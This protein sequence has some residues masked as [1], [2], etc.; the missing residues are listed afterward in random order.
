MSRSVV[1]VV[2]AAVLGAGAACGAD[3]AVVAQESS[4]APAESSSGPM[5]DSTSSGTG[6]TGGGESTSGTAPG[7]TGT[8]SS[9]EGEATHQPYFDVGQQPDLPP[10]D[11]TTGEPI[12]WDC[13]EL[14]QPFESET[15]LVGPRGYHDVYFN[16]DGQIIGW[17]GNSLVASTYEGE[18]SVFLPGVNSAQGMDVLENW[19]LLYVNDYGEM[20]MVTP[21]LVQ[22]TVSTAVSGAYG[23][24][25]GPDQLAYVSTYQGI[26][27]IDPDTG[28]Y[29][30]WLAMPGVNPRAMVFNLDSSGVYVSTLNGG[31]SSVYY[32]SVDNDLDPVEDEPFVVFA[33]NVG[34]GY[35]DGLGIDACGNLYVPDYNTRGLYRVDPE[36]V[37]TTLFNQDTASAA[38][39]GHGLKWG[40][41]I[42]GWNDK[43]IYLPQ[44]YDGNTV[45]EIV[46]GVPS[47]SRV[48]TW[49]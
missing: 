8:S 14:V 5:P 16:E 41:G 7:T 9:D 46:L 30:T 27:R 12:D 29:E 32:Q 48:R 2:F 34:Q 21:D 39:Y 15:E 1:V 40:S 35:H 10:D 20:R 19:D 31:S 38:H 43:A 3:P 22:T 33:N 42:D 37:V 44:P 45:L 11:S 28:E 23:I 49:N 13:D 6:S 17:D 47:G 4:G 26:I 25:V 18:V 24:T 36:G